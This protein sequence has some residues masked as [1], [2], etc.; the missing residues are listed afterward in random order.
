M[1]T[2]MG[3]LISRRVGARKGGERRNYQYCKVISSHTSATTRGPLVPSTPH[4]LPILATITKFHRFRIS[5][6]RNPINGQE[7]PPIQPPPRC[8]IETWPQRR[9][10]R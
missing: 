3:R 9:R 8:S 10:G 4:E 1:A 6:S 5:I 2:I 7:T